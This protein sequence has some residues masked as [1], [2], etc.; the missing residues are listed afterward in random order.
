MDPIRL[1]SIGVS[2]YRVPIETPVQTSFGVLR[3]RAAV[4][5]R[6]IDEDG[7]EGWGEIW[8]NFPTVGAEHRARLLAETVA[9]LA[10]GRAWA[11]P[12]ECFDALTAAVRVLAIQSGEP[13]PLA[14]VVAGVDIAMWDLAARR[15]QQPLWRMLGGRSGRVNVYASG[16]NPTQPERLAA[17][18]AAEGYTAFKL[19]IG[20]GAQRDVANLSNLRATV[21]ESARLMVDANQAWDV[22]EAL[23]MAGQLAPLRPLWLEEPI[24]A[25]SPIEEWQR[26]AQHSPIPLAAGENLRAGEFARFLEARC[27][28][29]L[30]PDVAKWGGFT[31]CLPLGEAAA[32]ASAWL[33][34]HWLGGGIGLLA[35]LHLKAAI[36]GEGF[37]EID[38]NPNPLRELLAGGLPPVREGAVALPE[39]P[40]LGARPEVAALAAYLTLERTIDTQ[41]ISE[42]RQP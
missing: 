3:D 19:K 32:N 16:L 6:A 4:V 36:G 22:E 14:Q 12:A 40:G 17:A 25:D 28:R 1:R 31:G 11:S 13:G 35:T 27:L 21:G 2:V 10:L 23:R 33:C 5:V 30:Q 8:C 26:L 18:K 20:F 37:T 9:P 7:R 41:Q 29:V 42:G 39:A 34:P 15:Q 38:A 24:A